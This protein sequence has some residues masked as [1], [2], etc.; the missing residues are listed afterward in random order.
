MTVSNVDVTFQ[1]YSSARYWH[2]E[3]SL[4]SKTLH[5]GLLSF[6]EMKQSHRTDVLVKLPLRSTAGGENGRGI[7]Q[8]KVGGCGRNHSVFPSS[9]TI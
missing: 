7:E 2:S 5:K 1:Q 6:K 3:Q 8:Q 4:V 9:N